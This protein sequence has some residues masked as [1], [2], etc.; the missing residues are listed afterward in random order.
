MHM[1]EKI[2]RA[3]ASDCEG[4]VASHTPGPWRAVRNSVFWQI[5]SDT[6]GQIGDTCSSQFIFIDGLT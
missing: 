1:E 4:R 3:D 5:D 6:H 2:E